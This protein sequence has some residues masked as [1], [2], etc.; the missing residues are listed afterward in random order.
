[1]EAQNFPAFVEPARLWPVAL[2]T[3]S[4]FN[5]LAIPSSPRPSADN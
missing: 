4:S 2:T 5:S 1:M 3:P